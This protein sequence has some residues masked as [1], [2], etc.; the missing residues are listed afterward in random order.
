MGFFL[1][2][3]SIRRCRRHVTD[4]PWILEFLDDPEY[5]ERDVTSRLEEGGQFL[6]FLLII[7]WEFTGILRLRRLGLEFP[8]FCFHDWIGNFWILRPGSG[9]FLR[10][11]TGIQEFF[12][13]YDWDP[14]IF[15]VYDWDP[16]IS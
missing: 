2:L 11:T 15:E 16:G 9:N 5:P 1:H 14:G 3:R 7:N 12:E 8:E 6:D 10:F 13:F 4:F